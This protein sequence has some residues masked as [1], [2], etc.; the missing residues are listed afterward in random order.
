MDAFKEF[1]GKS[2]DDAI[3]EA[4][5]YYNTT[6]EKLEIDIIQDFKSGIFGI[7]GARKAKIKARRVQLRA[8][9]EN[10]LGRSRGPVAVDAP[11]SPSQEAVTETESA[12]ITVA[13][14]DESRESKP[15]PVETT[16]GPKHEEYKQKGKPGKG[17]GR[18][19]QSGYDE[20]RGE[21]DNDGRKPHENEGR[22]AHESD[23]R[24]PLDA[25]NRKSNESEGRRTRDDKGYDGEGRKPRD[26][27]KPAYSDNR[28]PRDAERHEP[29]ARKP[30]GE[31][32]DGE[33]A[34]H[35]GRREAPAPRE[36]MGPGLND[37]IE[38][39][40][41]E[42]LPSMRLDDVNVEKLCELCVSTVAR[43]VTP[44]IGKTG[45]SAEVVDGRVNVS[46]D[47]GEDS[48][49]LIGRE[50]QTLASLQFL[51]SR[52]VSQSMGFIVRV[53]LDAGEYRLRQYEKLRE[54]ALALA[55]K[56]RTAGKS[57]S[58]R[59]MSSYHRRIIHMTLQDNP[60]VQTRS[61]GEG[62]LKRVVVQRR[63]N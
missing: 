17:E 62:P 31:S 48:G 7:V 16:R 8:T 40:E 21:R 13:R 9:V 28:K 54:L 25:E 47:C 19:R 5:N 55:E 60:D 46:I 24:K 15:R 51:S 12:E 44:I 43:L 38:E 39:M 34:R 1:E 63:K 53:Q 2:L 14:K 59:P 10:I 27:E 4:C 33:S 57:C 30:R 22:K 42:G 36:A 52:I 56:V 20:G 26:H 41:Q 18:P 3:R 29:E 50:G 45:L 58:T 35:R 49:L 6:R 37:F 23:G 11:E 32:R 61:T